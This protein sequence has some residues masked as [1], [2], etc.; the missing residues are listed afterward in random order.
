M[1][2]RGRVGG[3]FCDV[4][5][6]RRFLQ[7]LCIGSFLRQDDKQVVSGGLCLLFVMSTIGDICYSCCVL[8]PASRKCETCFDVIK[9]NIVTGSI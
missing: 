3:A 8:V 5:E 6:R 1:Y 9:G 4:D 7:V 2:G